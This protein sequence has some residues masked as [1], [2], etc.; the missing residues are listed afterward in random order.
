[1]DGQDEL[2]TIAWIA[3]RMGI[4]E[5]AV[6]KL[7]ARGTRWMGEW[8]ASE[9]GNRRPHVSKQGSTNGEDEYPDEHA[10]VQPEH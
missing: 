2:V 10:S 5:K 6:E 9:G 8:L 4:T 1:M 3:K 7:I